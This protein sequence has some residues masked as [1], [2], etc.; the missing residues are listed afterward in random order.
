MSKSFLVTKQPKYLSPVESF[1]LK[2]RHFKSNKSKH[3]LIKHI[4]Y[5]L[6][7][8]QSLHQ[9]LHF[10]P[11]VIPQQ[12]SFTINIKINKTTTSNQTAIFRGYGMHEAMIFS[13]SH[14]ST[15]TSLLYSQKACDIRSYT[16]AS[17][18]HGGQINM[19]WF[20]SNEKAVVMD[21]ISFLF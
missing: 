7:A 18:T 14:R 20:M 19:V 4:L 10:H 5:F 6:G 11:I 15:H 3:H 17:P 1:Y 13:S 21:L 8:S 12:N 2:H 16:A 9:S